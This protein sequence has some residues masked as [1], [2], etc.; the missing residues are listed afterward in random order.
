MILPS[1]ICRRRLTLFTLYVCTRTKDFGLLRPPPPISRWIGLNKQLID[2]S[3][4][5]RVRDERMV[6]SSTRNSIHG[7]VALNH[8]RSSPSSLSPPKH[9]KTERR[10]SYVARKLTRLRFSVYE[11]KT[12][13]IILSADRHM[14]VDKKRTDLPPS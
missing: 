8:Y 2:T 10:G 13:N 11:E 5:V 3:W 12:S 1:S 6:A 14:Y 4:C 9:P 7:W